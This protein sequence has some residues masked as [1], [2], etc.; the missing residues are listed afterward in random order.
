[1]ET[2]AGERL[3]ITGDFV[4]GVDRTAKAGGWPNARVIAAGDPVIC[5][6]APLVDGYL[7]D[8]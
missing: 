7:G 4:S 8:C 3:P 1:M 6:L 2:F 5:D